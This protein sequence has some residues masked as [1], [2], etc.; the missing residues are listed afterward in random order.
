MGQFNKIVTYIVDT[1]H[2]ISRYV[3]PVSYISHKS[4]LRHRLYDY[5]IESNSLIKIRLVKL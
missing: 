2:R 3:I 1:W 5:I 4:L